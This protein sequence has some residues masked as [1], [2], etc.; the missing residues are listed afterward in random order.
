MYD[1]REI[2]RLLKNEITEALG[3]TEPACAALAGAKVRDL[4][5]RPVE[6]AVVHVSRDMMKNA[7]GVSIPNSRLSGIKAA[8]SLGLATGGSRN[9]LSVL[10]LVG[11]EERRAAQGLDLDVELAENVPALYIAVRAFGG[12]SEAYASIENEHDRFSRL[13]KDGV[14]ISTGVS[15]ITE[16]PS[17]LDHAFLNDLT[18]SDIIDYA[19]KPDDGIRSLLL[20]ACRTN[21]EI[22]RAGIEE[23]WGLR[24]GATMYAGM[25]KVGS[26][27]DAMRKGACYAAAGSDARMSGSCRPVMINSGSGNQGITVTVPVAILAGYLGADED[28]L[29]SALA[30]SELVGLVLTNRKARLSALCG[31]FTASIGTAAAWVYLLGGGEQEMDAATNN[32][33]GNLT[34][35]ICDGAKRTCALK[36]YSSLI[37]ASV[38]VLLAMKGISAREESG[39]VGASGLE[40][41]LHLSRLSHEGMEETDRTILSIM[42]EKGGRN[43]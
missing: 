35:I 38:S 31:A 28:R 2:D 26:V 14:E 41:I 1:S 4:L 10:S 20:D 42:M 21:M 25:E 30:I 18:F 24:V 12:G 8:V 22:S 7:M 40:S 39:I 16:C 23:E 19:E 3:C 15:F 13:E 33:V 29:V 32:M 37:A 5:G 27:E 36:I 6:K 17:S 9:G 34:G 11:E 43:R